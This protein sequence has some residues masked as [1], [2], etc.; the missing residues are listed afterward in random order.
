MDDLEHIFIL[1]P[2]YGFE[3]KIFTFIEK[4]F[5]IKMMSR[6]EVLPENVS[7]QIAAGE[8]IERPANVVKELIENSLDA[9]AKRI[10]VYFRNGGTSF[11]QV[12]DDGQGMDPSDALLCFKRHATSKLHHI[13]D[14]QQLHSFG[15]RGEALPSIA[16]VSK[17]TLMTRMHSQEVGTKI[18]ADGE[19]MSEPTPCACSTGTT[20]I[21]QQ[22]FYNIPVRRKFL[23]S[24]A[25]EVAHIID[26]VRGYALAYPGICF[27]L[28]QEDRILFS[29]SKCNN[30]EERISEL[31]PKRTYKD[32]ISL[33]NEQNSYRLTGLLCPPHLTFSGSQ[34][35]YVFLNRRP[36]ANTFLLPILRECYRGYLNAKVTPSAFLFLGLPEEDV[37]INVHP[38]KREVRFKN[39][40]QV[41]N[42]ISSSI[43]KA[44]ANICQQPFEIPHT[45][46]IE[47]KKQTIGSLGKWV[48]DHVTN[49][50]QSPQKESQTSSFPL[51]SEKEVTKEINSNKKIEKIVSLPQKTLSF[52]ALWKNRFA[53][54]NEPPF[55]LVLDCKYAQARIWYE[56]I[57]N[58]LK[59]EQIGPL[60]TLMFPHSF[61]LDGLQAVT[62][63]ESVDYL[64]LKQICF[65]KQLNDNNFLL[66]AVPQ[67]L[68]LEQL[69]LFIYNLTESLLQRGQ[70]VS[71][72]QRF[73]P[74]LQRLTRH[75]NFETI[76]S[77]TQVENLYQHLQ[78]CA[79]Y[80]TDPQGNPLWGRLT[81]QDL[82]KK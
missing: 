80:I 60:Q 13:N 64:N 43:Q 46:P 41:R 77:Q 10:D 29:S 19:S 20:F 71:L 63:S 26:C 79:N 2:F 6:I 52:F 24:E 28:K 72:E 57:L 82:F 56:Q 42:F 11:I 36:I 51:S 40:M 67:W 59:K 48:C 47:E 38:T 21:V 1:T 44:L 8:V 53:F 23:K 76:S 17:V 27:S 69:D 32:W 68:P 55:L 74:L 81:E 33:E 35:L 37:D 3:K 4:H 70:M 62:L 12:S 9:Q 50:I 61:Q 25:T 54:F 7:N 30:L 5:S 66:E 16:S 22:L 45:A 65:I 14:L 75:Y 15:F 31:W 58:L 49:T 73:E 39:E 18:E 34:A 78:M